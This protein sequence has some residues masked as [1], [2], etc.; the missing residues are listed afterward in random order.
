MV[1]NGAVRS[2][3]KELLKGILIRKI[4]N[5][6]SE[7]EYKPFFQAIFNEKQIATASIIQSFYT[8][9]GMSIYEEIAVILAKNQGFHAEK[10]YILLGKIDGETERLIQ[11]T[12]LELRKGKKADSKE[13][14]TKIRGSI[15]SA[16]TDDKKGLN[17]PDRVVD[18]FIKSKD[19]HEYYFGVTTVK[20]NKEGFETHKRKLLRWMALR[21]SMEKD[22][23][24]DVA[25]VLP[26]NPY[27]PK[28]YLRFASSTLFDKDQFLVQET[29]WDL[30]GGKGAFQDLINVCKEVGEELRHKIDSI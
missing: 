23:K 4:D 21:M 8:S 5:Y 10:H 24:I 2:E 14:R 7:T 11:K 3:L 6:K 18:V 30:I 28:P 22:I 26:Y 9:F 16:D 25:T 20:P 29:F 27:F 12:H 17:D 19:G 13:E 15:K 1:L